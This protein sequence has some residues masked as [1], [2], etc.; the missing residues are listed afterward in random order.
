MEKIEIKK[1]SNT[2]FKVTIESETT[3]THTVTIPQEYYQRLTHGKADPET[4]LKK[5][6][7]FLLER[8]SNT[9]ILMSFELGVITRY[10]PEYERIIK[11]RVQHA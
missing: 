7:E 6:F 8:E 3:T 1:L 4:L 11:S 2:V 9:S 10:F 5:S